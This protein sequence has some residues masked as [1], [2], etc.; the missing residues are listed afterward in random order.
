[1]GRFVAFGDYYHPKIATLFIE[2]LEA[3][4]EQMATK[5]G[6]AQEVDRGSLLKASALA[7]SFPSLN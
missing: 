2:N 5:S 4:T 1:M 7:L 6:K 3:I